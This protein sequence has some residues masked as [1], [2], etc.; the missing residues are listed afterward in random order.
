ML[1]HKTTITR[2]DRD[3][4]IEVVRTQGNELQWAMFVQELRRKIERSRVLESAQAPSVLV[5]MHSRVQ[6]LE[7]TGGRHRR[8]VFTLAYPEEADLS[9]GQLS[10]LSIL[11]TALLGTRRGQVISVPAA[12]GL[13]AIEVESILYQP[14]NAALSGIGTAL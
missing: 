10:V 12:A 2:P 13:R 11:G 5:T 14:E 3:R 6:L 4:L 9:V 1:C 8:E 7:L